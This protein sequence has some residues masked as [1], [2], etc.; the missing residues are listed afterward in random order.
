MSLKAGEERPIT[1]FETRQARVNLTAALRWAARLGLSEGICN[2]F[3]LAV[4]DG[5]DQFLVNPMGYHW[6][7]LTASDL[8]LADKDRRILEGS[9]V[10]EDSAFFIHSRIHMAKPRARC[11]LHT[12]MPYAT[13]LCL[14][15]R[16][17]LLMASQNAI[18]FYGR[19]A[20][21]DDYR[22]LAFDSSEG[23]RLAA[24]MGEHDVAFLA[25]HGVI[26]TGPT[27]S[28]AFDDL[29][30]LE[31]A[32]Q[33][34]FI[35]QSSGRQLREIADPIVR[36]VAPVMQSGLATMRDLHFQTIRRILDREEPEYAH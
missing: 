21:I 35:A 5:G 20:Y 30:Y 12:H 26:V 28:D 31:R 34:Q 18:R 36:Q 23:D 8:V 27:V 6:S 9:N 19:I 24:A 14:L 32:C 10:V 4:T 3:S 17:R 22:G 7:E 29:Y 16:G 2:H 1:P 33:A 15:A 13:A 11:V 25:A